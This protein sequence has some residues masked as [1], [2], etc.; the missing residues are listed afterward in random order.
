[1]TAP[2]GARAFD[3]L[4]RTQQRAYCD[5]YGVLYLPSQDDD[6]DEWYFRMPANQKTP[7]WAPEAPESQDQYDAVTA[8]FPD[9]TNFEFGGID[10]YEITLQHGKIQKKAG[11][12]VVATKTIR[13]MRRNGSSVNNSTGGVIVVE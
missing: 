11:A 4:L 2:I 10:F 13:W 1:M 8:K 6:D 5:R 9:A 7:W 12:A 3:K